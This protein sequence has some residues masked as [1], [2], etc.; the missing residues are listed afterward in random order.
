MKVIIFGSTGMVGQGV[1]KEC[2][3]HADVSE[4]LTVVRTPT[5]GRYPKVK[6]LRADF[7]SLESIASELKGYDACLFCLGTPSAGK[8][9]DEYTRVTYD[10]TLNVAKVFLKQNPGSSFIYV[11]GE[12]ADS[13][14]KGS[15]MWARV[16]GKTENALL[17]MPFK[18]VH[19][20]RPG[21]IQPLD[22]IKSQTALYRW[23]YTL[24]KPVLTPIR[25]LFPN[26]ITTTRILGRAIIAAAQNGAPKPILFTKDFRPLGNYSAPQIKH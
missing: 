7:K 23:I 12:G 5:H 25:K 1:L 6:E 22:G 3:Q 17:A 21:L 8:S 18:H 14:E 15:V 24:L 13:S 11:S 20:F 26:S 16:R 4:V 9:E 2:I 19:I 10:L